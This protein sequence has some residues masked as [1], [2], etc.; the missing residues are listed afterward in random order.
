MTRWTRCLAP[1][2]LTLALGLTASLARA[3]NP[4]GQSAAR[5]EANGELGRPLDGYL[6]TG[7][8]A[9]IVLFAVGTSARRS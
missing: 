5:G 2:L 9:G 3:Q 4:P 7:V 1:A 8:L 6:A